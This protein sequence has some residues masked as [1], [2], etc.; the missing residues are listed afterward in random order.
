MENALALLT[1]DWFYKHA[2]IG[3]AAGYFFRVFEHVIWSTK[4]P[5]EQNPLGNVRFSMMILPQSVVIGAAVG[6]IF[7]A[8]VAL[9]FKNVT[10]VEISA[11]L[12]TGLMSFLATDIRELL[13]RISRI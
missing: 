10:V 2:A 13:R 4:A 12:L 9:N 5:P 8:I 6:Y 3:I 7:L 1:Y 11:Y